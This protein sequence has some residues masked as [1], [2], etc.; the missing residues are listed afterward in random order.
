MKKIKW[1]VLA[2]LVLA[3][4]LSAG[5]SYLALEQNAAKK[6]NGMQTKKKMSIA[7]VNEDIGVRTD[8]GEKI[9]F[10]DKFTAKVLKQ[11]DHKWATTSRGFAEN[12][13]KNR[14]Y[15]MI[16]FIPQ[17]F[18]KAAMS[19]TLEKPEKVKISYRISETG[20]KDVAAEA[21]RAAAAVLEDFNSQIIDVY[22]ASILTN[23]HGAQ[24]SIAKL[25]D[26]EETYGS[27]Y[28]AH[29]NSPLSNYTQQ[30]KTVQD[31]TVMSKDSFKGLQD[32]LKGFG[33]GLA[34]G[35]KTNETYFQSLE[36][37]AKSQ[38]TNALVSKSFAEQMSGNDTAMATADVSEQLSNLKSSN[39]AIFKQFQ[40][41]EEERT[42]STQVDSVQ[43]YLDAVNE[44]VAMIN[45]EVTTKMGESLRGSVEGDLLRY[46]SDEGNRNITL[47]DLT[48][49]TLNNRFNEEIQRLMIEIPN[50]DAYL[51]KDDASAVDRAV[52]NEL[53]NVI[54]IAG[55]YMSSNSGDW[56]DGLRDKKKGFPK[57]EVVENAIDKLKQ[58]KIDGLRTRNLDDGNY[59]IY[60]FNQD[61]QIEKSGVKDSTQKIIFKQPE[62]FAV[63]SSE[64][65]YSVK[66]TKEDGSYVYSTTNYDEAKQ[67]WTID[68][69]P[70]VTDP[71][72]SGVTTLELNVS[73]DL[74]IKE[75][76]LTNTEGTGFDLFAPIK[77]DMTNIE[78]RLEV[79][80]PVDPNNPPDPPVTNP[81]EDKNVN[82]ELGPQYIIT[83]QERDDAIKEVHDTI[84]AIDKETTMLA[85]NV[86]DY[87]KP[88][89]KLSEL[90][91]T[92][93]GI[94]AHVTSLDL[95]GKSLTEYA[96]DKKNSYY[97]Q[98]NIENRI[99]SMV[100]LITDNVTNF[101]HRDLEIFQ[102]QVDESQTRTA[103]TKENANVLSERLTETTTQAATMNT[104]VAQTL[105]NV[106]AW[107]KASL[108]LLEKGGI[109]VT[110]GGD[111]KSATLS[112]GSE[113]GALLSQSKSLAD[114]S[115]T[116]LNSADNVYKT[117]DAID[118]QAKNIQNSGLGI[119]TQAQKLSANMANKLG[120]DQEFASNFADMMKN[121]RV[122][123]RQNEN[124]YSFL[125][126]PVEK[127]KGETIAAGD[128]FTPY[129]IVLVCFI[130]ALFTGYVI[131]A[132]ER[133][134]K[135]EDE[136]AEEMALVYENTP[137]TLMTVGI[138]LIEG[139]IIGAISA[140]FLEMKGVIF[141][142]WMGVIILIVFVFVTISTYLLRQLRM[143][144]MFLLLV[145]LALYLF[146]TEA[147]GLKIDQD[148]ML[149]TIRSLS[150]LQYVENLLNGFMSRTDDWLVL[151]Y[152]LIGAAVVGIIVNL[153]VWHRSKQ[154]GGNDDEA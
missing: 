145:I 94:D 151:M 81:V 90:F 139:A 83:T 58:E 143:I 78:T 153:F 66:L 113:F 80:E 27:I 4:L 6:E 35:T 19:M 133:K 144:G 36:K 57:Y 124:L 111:E 130:V 9:D 40:K 26:K 138:A 140:Y 56:S 18:S 79:E 122:G 62:G 141:V 68:I 125:S 60:N 110:N 93:Y 51:L 149:A 74:Y 7:L 123:D 118:K 30:F 99:A 70:S 12:G 127:V 136:F 21:E 67:E 2:F 116:N 106:E 109:V 112:L 84:G 22:F 103:I 28:D 152:S 108:E 91:K 97:Y 129:L 45:T 148:S 50:Y 98:F 69:D 102:Q 82:I 49:K 121:S 104:S 42:L 25:V 34:E 24:D 142:S 48:D 75:E 76:V 61:F 64:A 73:I 135:Q 44:Q 114:S 46:I 14:V 39:D 119:V 137:I 126:N 100:T 10:G 101:I 95:G 41:M 150:P 63:P 33:T 15:D 86:A 65:V 55:R 3:L 154:A 43:T 20:N 107:R 128:T 132:Q 147:V 120:T 85:D 117:F 115:K 105:A 96:A 87:V 53:R 54:E 59:Y 16:I 31:Y 1:S 23:L 8:D 38:E 88:Y 89:Y 37:L 11:T 134:R 131:A 29:V 52:F 72:G 5:T 146:L 77:V 71:D 92:Y 17:D 32:I 47:D 13:L